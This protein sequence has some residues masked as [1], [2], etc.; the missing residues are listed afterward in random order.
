MEALLSALKS[1][2]I[3]FSILLAVFGVVEANLQLFAQFLPA[4][5]VGI[6][7]LVVGLIVAILRVVTTLP[8]SQK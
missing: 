5:A 1:K 8:L 3:W 2:T 4:E 6:F 7:S